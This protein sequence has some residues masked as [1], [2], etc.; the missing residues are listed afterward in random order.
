MI[1]NKRV[2]AGLVLSITLVAPGLA[3]EFDRRGGRDAGR[4][5]VW[6]GEI[7]RFQERDLALWR[8]GHWYHG[9]HAGRG[10]WW[11][12]V[13]GI[14]YFYPTPMYPYPDPY[15]PPMVSVP[16]QP[17]PAQTWYYCANPAGYYPYVAECRVGWQ[18]VPASPPPAPATTPYPAP[19]P[20]GR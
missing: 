5:P 18:A 14:W 3:D 1:L 6:H 19:P 9:R 15:L 2:L 8:G 12:I 10:G 11:W 20:P 13:G 4:H 16:V 7:H 17:A